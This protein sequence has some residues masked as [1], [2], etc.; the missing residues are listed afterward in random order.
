MSA[1]PA[2]ARAYVDPMGRT[3]YAVDGPRGTYLITCHR[4]CDP[5]EVWRSDTTYSVARCAT[6]DQAVKVAARRAGAAVAHH[7]DIEAAR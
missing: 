3:Q 6:V 4:S 2:P 1:P 5:W 7:D